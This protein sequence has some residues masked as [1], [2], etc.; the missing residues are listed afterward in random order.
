MA[1]GPTVPSGSDSSLVVDLHPL[2]RPVAHH[3]AH[4][5]GEVADR[6]GEPVEAAVAQLVH[7]HVEDRPV[8][9]RGSGL[10]S[11]VV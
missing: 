3:G 2:A 11:T 9:H 5:M 10:G 7:D 1:S 4:Q 6:Q 8:A